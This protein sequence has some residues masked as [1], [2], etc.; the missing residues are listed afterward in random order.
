[1]NLLGHKTPA[2]FTHYGWFCGLVPIV[3]TDPWKHEPEIDTRWWCPGL[4]LETV[5]A[6][7]QGFARLLGWFDPQAD[8]YFPIVVT[9]VI[10]RP[11]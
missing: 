9:G 8:L 7:Y 11:A 1:M 4:L 5:A 2:R 3:M 10:R 6:L